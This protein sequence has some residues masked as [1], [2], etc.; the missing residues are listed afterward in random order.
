MAAPTAVLSDGTEGEVEEGAFDS[1]SVFLS[2]SSQF[3]LA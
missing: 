2:A 1:S 3:A